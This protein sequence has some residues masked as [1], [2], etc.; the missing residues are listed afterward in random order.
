MNAKESLPPSRLT[1]VAFAVRDVDHTIDFY[2]RYT[3]MQVVHER[4]SN[5][6][7]SKVVWLRETEGS[8]AITLVIFQGSAAD[9]DAPPAAQSM[10]HLG[11]A[12][13]SREAVDAIAAR[14]KDEGVLTLAPADHGE[15]VGYICTITD[16]DGNELEFSYGQ[17]L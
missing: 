2:R 7:G 8:G 12:V 1:H 6:S 13:E 4:P 17:S 3:T 15:I 14:A 10:H 5:S 9:D 11:F 16:P